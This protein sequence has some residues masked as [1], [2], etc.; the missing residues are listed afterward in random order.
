MLPRGE[1]Q[2]SDRKSRL[3]CFIFIIS[4]FAC[5]ISVKNIDNPLNYYE[6]STFD[7]ALTPPKGSGGG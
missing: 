7:L 1:T 5:Q 6:I 4:L 2:A 3:I